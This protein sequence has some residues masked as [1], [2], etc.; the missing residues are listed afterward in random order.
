[1]SDITQGVSSAASAA[2]NQ[3]KKLGLPTMMAICVGLVIV[4]GAMISALQG[5]GIGGMAFIA[6]MI[7][8]LVLAQFNAMS[9]A[10]LSLMFPE[11]GTLATYT[12]KAI[13]HFPA[14][15]SVFAG[16]V[17]VAILALPVEMFLV[18]AMLGQLLP[19]FLPEKAAPLIILG[20]F[21]ITNLIGTDVFAK[22]QNLLAF[23]LITALILIGLVAITGAGEPHPTLA[24]P[25]VDW[26]FGGVLDGS[27]IG[28]V[29]LA[30]WTMV[31]VEFICPLV[32][33]V[34][35]PN[36]NIPRAMHLSLFMIFFIFLGFTYGASLYLDIPSLL[37]SPLPYLDY[38]NA[39][40]GQSGLII[41]TVMALA[42][43]CSTMNTVLAAVPR[44][45]Q[46]MG[47]QGQVFP[48][49]KKTNRFDAPWVGTLMISVGASIPFFAF[50]IDSLIVLVIAA[51]TSWL[52]AYCVAHIN[53]IV[54]RKRQPNQPRPYRTPF[55]PLPQIL[56]VAGMLYVALNNSPTPEMTQMVYSI[57]GGILLVIGII[58][59]VW[60]KFVMKRGLFEV[61]AD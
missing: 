23:I 51:T 21:T 8:A 4:Q 16:Y 15:V 29:G 19:G 55:Y 46:G 38:A 34:K 53:V 47:D 2:A 6:A 61:D 22:V 52:L 41:A 39:V 49:L 17:V 31:G 48:M 33:D 10:E 43:T 28:L 11:K 14:I 1:M 12:Q 25:S 36:K 37:E 13:G 7:T 18:D 35:T 24:G 56:G 5:I 26:S 44:M 45:L 30:L 9:F 40:F 58:G 60:V 54:L 50:S 32:N 59:A 20:L 42:A 27:F 3:S 57:T